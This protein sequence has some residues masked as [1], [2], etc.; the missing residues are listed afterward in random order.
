MILKYL[1]RCAAVRN[2]KGHEAMYNATRPKNAIRNMVTL[3]YLA[4]V[5]QGRFKN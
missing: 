1:D 5:D 3:I 4:P 2:K